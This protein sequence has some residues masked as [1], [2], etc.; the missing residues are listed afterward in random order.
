[1]AAAGVSEGLSD[2]LS[3]AGMA[4]PGRSAQFFAQQ[5]AEAAADPST[6]YF[7]VYHVLW[8]I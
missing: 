8:V 3:D 4:V 1:M 6:L 5:L 2:G 7:L